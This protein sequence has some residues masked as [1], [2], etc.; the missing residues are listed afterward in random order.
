MKDRLVEA[1]VNMEEEEA[2][3]LANEMLDGGGDPM[4]VVGACKDALETVGKQFECGE[5]FL[6][7]LMMAGEMMEAISAVVKPRLQG[8]A[9]A[10]R[11]G[12]IIIGTVAGDV[13][14]IGKNIA[15]F[16][17]DSQGFEVID[18]GVD[19]PPARFVETIRESGAK[20]VALSGLLTLAFDSMKATVDAIAGAGLR[21]QVK[22]MIGGAPVNEQVRSYAGADAWGRDAVHGVNLAKQWLGGVA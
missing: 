11:I 8:R 22:I 6:P 1:F 3:R 21:D 17:L 15:V 12:K 20:V 14:D 9:E 7:E 19:V 10:A 18:L 16:L 5:A 2:L 13:H 4:E